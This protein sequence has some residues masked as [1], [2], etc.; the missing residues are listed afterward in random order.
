MFMVSCLAIFILSQLRF[1]CHLQ[2]EDLS[3]PDQAAETSEMVF[4]REYTGYGDVQIKKDG[5]GCAIFPQL[6]GGS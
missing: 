5:A 3:C 4:I 1:V 2:T 6:F